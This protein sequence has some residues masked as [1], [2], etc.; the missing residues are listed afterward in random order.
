MALRDWSTHKLEVLWCNLWKDMFDSEPQT[1][2]TEDV[3]GEEHAYETGTVLE[4]FVRQVEN[5]TP[6]QLGIR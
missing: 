1:L 2:L 4:I 6:E 3:G 5:N